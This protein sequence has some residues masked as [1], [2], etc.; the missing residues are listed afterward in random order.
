M[1]TNFGAYTVNELN[2]IKNNNIDM[3]NNIDSLNDSQDNVQNIL[4]HIIV[5]K[6]GKNLLN[7]N[8]LTE[9]WLFLSS[10]NFTASE[11]ANQWV[12]DF[13]PVD[14]SKVSNLV[15]SVL[16]EGA[17]TATNVI[18][19][20]QYDGSKSFVIGSGNT[21]VISID[22]TTKYI[23]VCI[24]TADKTR[25]PQLEIGT[26]PTEYE[27]YIG[28]SKVQ[29]INQ[30]QVDKN[31][32]DIASLYSLIDND[33]TIK[34]SIILVF[35]DITNDY[36]NRFNL[37][38]NQFGF[39]ANI[40]LNDGITDEILQNKER[41]S[42]YHKMFS[43]G[44]DW[45]QY[46]GDDYP[47]NSASSEELATSIKSMQ[48]RFRNYG[49]YNPIIYFPTQNYADTN[50]IDALKSLGFRLVR[51]QWIWGDD[52][53]YIKGITKD[54]FKTY[55]V[56]INDSTIS[57]V[58]GYIDRACENGWG[59]SIMTHQLLETGNTN[60]CSI[61]TYTELLNY[62]KS[63]IDSGVCEVVTYREYYNRYMQQD[64]QNIDWIRNKIMDNYLFN[65]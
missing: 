24:Q 47:G 5:T 19:S 42:K 36:E 60:N 6:S 22:N 56:T 63:K 2:E 62:I 59:L 20:C 15:Y 49:L 23:R 10:G 64:G 43:C 65:K 11:D 28:E 44:W 7:I 51:T 45:G 25:S 38:Y 34:G 55:T 30:D 21:K 8:G 50:M 17:Q 32:E 39:S 1:Y 3:T 35:D 41:M 53:E 14:G 40:A 57:D 27:E 13:I 48:D 61:S 4:D 52:K 54:T 37:V 26:E 46:L 9:G 33:D 16:Y 29:L 12:T 18:S 31:T 58:K